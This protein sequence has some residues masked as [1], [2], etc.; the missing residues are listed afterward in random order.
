[1]TPS[2]FLPANRARISPM[3]I[4]GR[5]DKPKMAPADANSDPKAIRPAK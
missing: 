2:A 5:R 3:A 4:A 1:M